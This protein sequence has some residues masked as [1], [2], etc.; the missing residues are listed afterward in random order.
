MVQT[1][2][3][4]TDQRAGLAPP[5][6]GLRTMLGLISLIC[7]CLAA[8]AAAGPVIG[9]A[10]LLAVFVVAAH[11]AGNAIGSQ[12][13]HNGNRP[14]SVDGDNQS[15]N[16]VRRQPPDA[17]H[18][19]PQ[20]RLSRRAPLGWFMRIMTTLGCIAGAV[21]GGLFLDATSSRPLSYST[22]IF[23]CIAMGV[24]GGLFAFWL[25]SLMQVFL[26]AWWQ[27]HQHGHQKRP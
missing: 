4:H 26:L 1:E 6:F 16:R 2:K 23:G 17:S 24:L 9:S 25:F 20:T 15:V 19:A 13:R 22:M 7:G 10:L 12:L 8:F 27:A 3:T 11:V 21:A 18:F 14:L 5:R